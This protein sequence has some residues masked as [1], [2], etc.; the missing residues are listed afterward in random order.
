MIRWRSFGEEKP[1]DGVRYH[2]TQGNQF[3]KGI[4]SEEMKGFLLDGCG[5]KMISKSCD[6]F[7]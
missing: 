1:L 5:N 7:R 4:W 2:Y 3:F 6:Y